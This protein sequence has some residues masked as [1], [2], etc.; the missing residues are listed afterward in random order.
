M[1]LTPNQ[2]QL[3]KEYILRLKDKRTLNEQIYIIKTM[4]NNQ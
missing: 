1:K 4:N 3:V 2:K